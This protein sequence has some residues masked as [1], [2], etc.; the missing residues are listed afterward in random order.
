MQ[1]TNGEAKIFI[2]LKLKL[3]CVHFNMINKSHNN[4]SVCRKV[5]LIKIYALKKNLLHLKF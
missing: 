4:R 3:N 5:F 2:T 1:N